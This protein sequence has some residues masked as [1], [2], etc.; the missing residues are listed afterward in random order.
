M[1]L[2]FISP[3]G[4]PGA[5]ESQRA[6]L[7]LACAVVEVLEGEGSKHWEELASMEKVELTRTQLSCLK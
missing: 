7:Q 2:P 3:R 1:S 4:H 6:V 5:I